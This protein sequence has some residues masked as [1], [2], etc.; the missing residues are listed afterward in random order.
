MFWL[1]CMFH[2]REINNQMSVTG[3]L[4]HRKLD[5]M[6]NTYL[7]QQTQWQDTFIKYIKGLICLSWATNV[8]GHVG[9]KH[10]CSSCYPESECQSCQLWGKTNPGAERTLTEFYWGVYLPHAWFP[11]I[12]KWKLERWNAQM[13]KVKLIP[14]LRCCHTLK[15]YTV[16]RYSIILC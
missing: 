9:W 8:E 1:Y 16:V 11:L 6:A 3:F 7:H 4:S 10:S 12:Q 5:D 15:S 2:Y 14:K 13:S